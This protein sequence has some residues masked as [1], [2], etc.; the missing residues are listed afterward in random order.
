MSL[1]ARST[2]LPVTTRAFFPNCLANGPISFSLPAPN[3]MCCAVANSNRIGRNVGEFNTRAWFGHYWCNRITP[4]LVM[5]GFLVRSRCFPRA[6]NLHQNKSGWIILLLQYVKSCD[7]RFLEAFA[8][9]GQGYTFEG[10]DRVRLDVNVDVNNQHKITF[11][12]TSDAK[13]FAKG[14]IRSR[15]NAQG[16]FLPAPES[17]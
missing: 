12:F 8:C 17:G 6:V 14:L 1:V 5:S 7:T 11:D 16:Y 9:V 15:S 4:G 13:R 3:R 2:P 10:F